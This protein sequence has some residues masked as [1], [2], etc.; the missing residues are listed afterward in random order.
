M[1]PNVRAEIEDLAQLIATA[2]KHLAT[3]RTVDLKG[4]DERVKTLCQAI[5]TDP[6]EQKDEISTALADLL[7]DIDA[8]E[9]DL[10]AR[11]DAH[12]DSGHDTLPGQATSTYRR[13]SEES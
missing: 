10:V 13:N 7:Q 9:S 11:Q 5:E 3:H 4:L 1:S 6:P 12:T 2:R 8:L